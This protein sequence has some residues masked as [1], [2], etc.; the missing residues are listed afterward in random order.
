M[1]IELTPEEARCLR[2][3]FN[4]TFLSDVRSISNYD[5]ASGHFGWIL[6][7]HFGLRIDKTKVPDSVVEVLNFKLPQLI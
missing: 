2:A 3:C 7:A 5:D 4:Y 6:E 1:K